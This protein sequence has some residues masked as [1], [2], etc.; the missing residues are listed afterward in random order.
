MLAD[1]QSR[2]Y[3]VPSVLA[4]TAREGWWIEKERLPFLM[5]RWEVFA[6]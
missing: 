6:L 4:C 5:E 3:L 1:S 2:P